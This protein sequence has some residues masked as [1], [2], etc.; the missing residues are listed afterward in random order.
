M[1]GVHP[2]FAPS[3]LVSGPG[4]AS[5]QSAVKQRLRWEGGRFH[6]QRKWLLRLFTAGMRRRDPTL[7]STA[8]DLATPPLGIL[9]IGAA[10]G[11]AIT[12]AAVFEGVAPAWALVPWTAALLAIPAFVVVGLLSAGAPASVWRVVVYAPEFLVWKVGAYVRLLKGFDATRWERSARSSAPPTSEARVNIAGVP[13][14]LVGM[15][16]AIAR[17]ESAIGGHRLVQ[18]STINLDFLVRA[19]RDPE[20][21]RIFQQSLNLAD[22]A[23]IVWLGRLLGVRMPGRVANSIQ[24]LW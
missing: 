14:D 15:S 2:R 10:A 17:L 24:V 16:A 19:Q 6:V 18:V 12:A 1:A 21:R 13:I 3:A 22:G 11:E 23:P 7:L 4:P 9:C 20:I 8:L 5:R